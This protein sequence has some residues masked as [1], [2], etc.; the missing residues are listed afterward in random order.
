[1]HARIARLV[2]EVGTDHDDGL[3]ILDGGV[4]TGPG[5]AR[6]AGPRRAALGDK[7]GG[8]GVCGAVA[9]AGAELVPLAQEG[10]D[11]VIDVADEGSETAI[12]STRRDSSS[13]TPTA[14]IDFPPPGSSPVM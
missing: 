11:R 6:R 5:C 13:V 2:S 8:L 12:R 4:G 7:R 14:M 1:M 3:R 10:D 9:R